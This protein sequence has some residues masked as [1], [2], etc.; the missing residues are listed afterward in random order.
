LILPEGPKL[1]YFELRG[2]GWRST[3]LRAAGRSPPGKAPKM[4]LTRQWW[5]WQFPAIPGF[6]R[7]SLRIAKVK[8]SPFNGLRLPLVPCMRLS[9]WVSTRPACAFGPAWPWVKD[10]PLMQS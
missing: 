8:S 6:W 5:S 3:Y 1:G 9:L 7:I 4:A 2:L 10:L